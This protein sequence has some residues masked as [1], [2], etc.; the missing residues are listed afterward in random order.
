MLGRDSDPGMLTEDEWRTSPEVAAAPGNDRRE[1][2]D[3]DQFGGPITHEAFR[4]E[5]R[6]PVPR[7]RRLASRT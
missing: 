2:Y 7:T 5:G 1:A 3:P 6:P 4:S